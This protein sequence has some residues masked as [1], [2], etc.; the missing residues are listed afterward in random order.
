MYP[1]PGEAPHGDL[2][3]LARGGVIG[4]LSPSG[5]TA[6]PL[7]RLPAVERFGLPLIGQGG[8]DRS[9]LAQHGDVWLDVGVPEEACPLNPAPTATASSMAALVGASRWRGGLLIPRAAEA[10][11]L[12]PAEMEKRGVPVDVL[13]TC[14]TVQSTRN[15]ESLR[16]LL[17]PTRCTP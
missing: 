7:G 2:G 5:E 16:D 17:N 9:T 8:N 4:P 1:E 11:E 12:L 10:R 6:E 14:R 15:A 3:M 13:P